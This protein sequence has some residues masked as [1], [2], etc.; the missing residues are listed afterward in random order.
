MVNLRLLLGPAPPLLR[1]VQHHHQHMPIMDMALRRLF[2]NPLP[3]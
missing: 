3:L 2:V 1:Q